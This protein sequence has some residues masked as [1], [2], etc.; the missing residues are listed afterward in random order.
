MPLIHTVKTFFSPLKAERKDVVLWLSASLL[1][2]LLAYPGSAHFFQNH[3]APVHSYGP[4]ARWDAWMYHHMAAGLLLCVIPW[5]MIKGVYKEK[6]SEFGLSLG[7][8]KAGVKLLVL[9][10]VILPLPL[11]LTSKDPAFL[12]E[13]PLS[14]GA[15]IS[16]MHF[17]LWCA[18]MLP[19]FFAWEF[20]Y[21]GFL[22][23][24]LSKRIGVFPA[25]GVQVAI[26]T[27]AHIG[28]PMGETF[29]AIYGGVLLTLV[30]ISTRSMLW[31]FLC[32]FYVGI[33]VHLFCGLAQ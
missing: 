22:G 21:R 28:K 31:P 6:V 12:R 7:D 30:S 18:G 4:D 10:L 27:I 20:F 3:F 29:A 15:M 13:Y 8:W 9:A 14:P 11:W 2:A 19:Y 24:G 23:L 17:V 1:P 5:L 32:H 26:S 16:P 33:L 25:M